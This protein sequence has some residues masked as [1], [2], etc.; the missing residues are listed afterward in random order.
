MLP[1]PAVPGPPVR[2]VFPD[3]GLTEVRVVW[4][5]PA[6]PNGII[7]GKRGVGKG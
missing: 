6:D 7:L 1:S 4:Q 2:L 3:V 5:P